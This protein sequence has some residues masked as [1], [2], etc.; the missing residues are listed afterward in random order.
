PFEGMGVDTAWEL[1]MPK[2]ANPFDYNT[3][4]DVLFT[5]EYTALHSFDYRQQVIQ[6]MDRSISADRSFSL[7]QQF[8]DQWYDL[9]NPS[10]SVTPMTISFQTLREDFPPNLEALSI[11]QVVLYFIRA[12]A[13]FEVPATSLQFTAQDGSGPY[14]GAAPASIDGI[15]STR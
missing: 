10:Q 5:I 2:A 8:P 15:I 12:Q 6:R 13:T 3:I 9:P 11:A 7:R 4:V 14:G 1:Q